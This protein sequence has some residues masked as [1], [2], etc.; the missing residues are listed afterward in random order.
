V[1]IGLIL[2]FTSV[3][4]TIWKLFW[5]KSKRIEEMGKTFQQRIKKDRKEG[6][7]IIILLSIGMFLQGLS[8]FVS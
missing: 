3:A 7:V 5:G 1:V 8:V 2:E 6:T 4:V